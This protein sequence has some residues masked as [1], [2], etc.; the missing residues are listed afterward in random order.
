MLEEKTKSYSRILNALAG[1]RRQK[2]TPPF[3]LVVEDAENLSPQAIQEN[4][5][6]KNSGTV[7]ITSHPSLLGGETLSKMQ[8][9]IVGRTTD[10][11]D[12]KYLQNVIGNTHE[13]LPSLGVGEM[14]I[15]GLNV[16]RPTKIHVRQRLS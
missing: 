6:L 16:M 3:V 10:P 5:S 1:W 14:V 4:L 8:T 12:M 11:E 7:L 13:Q 15:N 2:T 9:Q